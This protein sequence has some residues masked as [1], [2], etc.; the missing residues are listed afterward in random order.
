LKIFEQFIKYFLFPLV[1]T[2]AIS[3]FIDYT[4]NYFLPDTIWS[5][6]SLAKAGLNNEFCEFHGLDLSI[7]QPV[8]AWSNMSFIFFGI[9]ILVYGFEDQYNKFEDKINY[10]KM[11][12]SFSFV[13]GLSM[14]F[15]G[16]GSF[17]FHASMIDFSSRLDITGVVMSCIIVFSYSILRLLS[18]INYRQSKLFFLK[19]YRMYIFLIL[20]F[21]ILFFIFNFRGR[22]VTLLLVL[23]TIAITIYTQI[24]YNPI[25][26][27]KYFTAAFVS[28]TVSIILWLLDKFLICEPE[29]YI[30]LHAV[31]H[32][33]TSLTVFLIYT[34]YRSELLFKY[35]LN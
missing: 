29:S 34:F 30:Q 15:L 18:L 7:R 22:E 2:I 8:N 11:Y 28:I 19:T 17:L 1:C 23:G 12:S 4:F 33:L 10:I 21:S 5:N 25:I 24:K 3:I 27:L 13:L 20:I 35:H 32:I 26:K 6:F 14:I 31:W 9:V 16:F